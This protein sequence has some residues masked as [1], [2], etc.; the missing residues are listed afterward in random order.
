MKAHTY[1]AAGV[2]VSVGTDLNDDSD[3]TVTI[4]TRQDTISCPFAKYHTPRWDDAC[5]F[6]RKTH[7]ILVKLESQMTNAPTD[8]N[9]LVPLRVVLEIEPTGQSILV[10]QTMS[11]TTTVF[12]MQGCQ[13]AEAMTFLS[14][15]LQQRMAVSNAKLHSQVIVSNFERIV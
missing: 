11:P 6:A 13:L 8:H 9:I 5:L 1:Q 3:Y 4:T 12:R 14:N 10:I 7:E 15:F 2:V